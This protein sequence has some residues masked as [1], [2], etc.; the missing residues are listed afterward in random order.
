MCLFEENTAALPWKRLLVVPLFPV[1]AAQWD[2]TAPS[3]AALVLSSNQ[4]IHTHFL[5][6]IFFSP[7]LLQAT[8]LK[9]VLFLTQLIHGGVRSFARCVGT[10]NCRSAEKVKA[11]V[12]ACPCICVCFV[13]ECKNKLHAPGTFTAGHSSAPLE[14]QVHPIQSDL[15]QT[16]DEFFKCTL[17]VS[18]SPLSFS[19]VCLVEWFDEWVMCCLIFCDKV[20]REKGLERVEMAAVDNRLRTKCIEHWKRKTNDNLRCLKARSLSI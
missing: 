7:S 11:T 1:Y 20:R 4:H 12:C 15:W 5:F 8:A 10:V 13:P 14:I 18:V 19:L 2:H 16:N 3:F 9:K 17:P 6:S